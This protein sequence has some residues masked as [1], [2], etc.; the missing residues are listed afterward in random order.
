MLQ[1]VHLENEV[2]GCEE[3]MEVFM[4]ERIE[5]ESKLDLLSTSLSRALQERDETAT[6]V[7]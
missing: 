7:V 2:K 4:Q 5:L 6:L 1:Q 3:T